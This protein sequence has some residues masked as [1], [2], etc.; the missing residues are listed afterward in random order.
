MEQHYIHR[1]PVTTLLLRLGKTPLL[2]PPRPVRQLPYLEILTAATETAL[3][4]GNL[5]TI[6]AD[7]QPHPGVG[8][9]APGVAG[10][11][12]VALTLEPQPYLQVRTV[13][14]PAAT[15]L[16]VPIPGETLT[17]YNR[18]VRISVEVALGNRLELQPV[19]EAGGTLEIRGK[20]AFQACD[21]RACYPPQ[22]VPLLWTFSLRPPDLERPPEA[23][24]YREKGAKR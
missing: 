5:V 12:G 17:V 7:L 16:P 4:P 1:L 8:V 18:P 15:V 2:P 24:Q 10:Y 14:Y 13:H 9:Y 23:L 6:Y 19:Y 20:L 22:E 3:Y 21:D 11:Q